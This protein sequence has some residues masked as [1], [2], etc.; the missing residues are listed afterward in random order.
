MNFWDENYSIDGYKYGTLPNEFLVEQSSSFP[1]NAKI[2][3][4]GDGEGRNGVWLAEQGHQVTTLDSSKGGIEKALAFAKTRGVTI[5]ALLADLSEWE[6]ESELADIVVLTYL[7]L[8]PTLRRKVH[9]NLAIA[10]KPNGFLVLEAFHPNQLRFQSGGPK[11]L[12]ML[13][14]IES[15]RSDFDKLLDEKFACECQIF[16]EEGVG[17][18]GPAFVTRW[19]GHKVM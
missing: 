8:E 17:H 11:A 7:H 13:Y 9:Q 16:L 1:K 2:L 10:L 15:L 19:V 6:P 12:N 14:S 18:Q 4:P 5:K 3:L